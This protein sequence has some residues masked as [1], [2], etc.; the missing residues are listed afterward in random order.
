MP[1]KADPRTRKL[2]H[3]VIGSCFIANLGKRPC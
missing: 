1:R 3:E 2:M